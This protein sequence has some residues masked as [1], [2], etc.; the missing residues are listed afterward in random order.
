[1]RIPLIFLLTLSL[2]PAQLPAAATQLAKTWN[3]QTPLD[4]RQYWVS[5]KLDGIRARWT[6]KQLLSRNGHPFHPPASFTRGFPNTVMDGELW[7]DRG[8]FQDVAATV[9]DDIPDETAWGKVK[10]MLFDLPEHPGSF[11]QRIDAMQALVNE[12]NNPQLR[13][14]E[15]YRIADQASLLKALKEVEQKGGE[16]LM[17]QHQDHHYS[18]GR[19]EALLKVK[20]YADAEATVIGYTAGKGKYAGMTGALRVRTEEGLEFKLGSGLSDQLRRH[21]PA[22]GSVITYKFYGKT[23]SGKPRF[24]S[25]MRVR[26]PAG[27]QPPEIRKDPDDG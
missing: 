14:I 7:I 18:D 23:R 4:V 19:T 3:A 25:F 10:L 9:R 12:A 6:G 11:T 24:A 5:E 13:M 21:P 26:I 1:M 16:G 22:I 27:E 20:S 17:L 2:F 8:R 15:Q